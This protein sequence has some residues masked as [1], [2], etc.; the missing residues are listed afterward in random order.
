MGRPLHGSR[1]ALAMALYQ[2]G[3]PI[4]LV[5]EATGLRSRPSLYLAL[6]KHGVPLRRSKERTEPVE[7]LTTEPLSTEGARRYSRGEAVSLIASDLG[8]SRQA[9]YK[10]ARRERKPKD[11]FG[12]TDTGVV[13]LGK[14]EALRQALRS[15]V[16]P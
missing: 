7:I 4:L 13:D 15:V 5:L 11:V 3:A 12:S 2:S 14:A 1:T 6:R 8:I 10:A 9:I 16:L